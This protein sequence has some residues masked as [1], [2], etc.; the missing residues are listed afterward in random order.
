[1]SELENLLSANAP[2]K[3]RNME[4]TL[5]EFAKSMTA[6]ELADLLEYRC[7]SFHMDFEQGKEV[8]RE[9]RSAHRTLQATAFRYLLGIVVGL[10]EQ[11]LRF[12]DAR[13]ETAVKSA[14]MLAQMIEDDELPLGYM[15]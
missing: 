4:F 14:Q 12:V 7:N 8:G 5:R 11:D 10:G 6:G 3:E 9:L 2:K 13:N 1:M 15:I